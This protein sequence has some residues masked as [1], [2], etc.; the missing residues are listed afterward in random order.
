MDTTRDL[1][2]KRERVLEQMRAIRSMRRGSV[3]EQYLK[4]PHKGKQK[5]VVR[6]PYWVHTWKDG[7][8]TVGQ[9]LSREE[10]AQTK[11]GIE[12]HKKFVALCKEFEALT[13]S[14][15]ELE[16]VLTAEKK[17]PRSRSSRI[18]R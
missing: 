17:R 15:G 14:L 11:K 16:G 9:R 3:T 13:M 4:V 5:P 7:G 1:E 8:K 12:A 6:G 18:K 2:Q 10:A